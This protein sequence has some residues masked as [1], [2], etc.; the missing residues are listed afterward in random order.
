MVF[1]RDATKSKHI[2]SC[3]TKISHRNHFVILMLQKVTL[4]KYMLQNDV[5][6]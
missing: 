4:S 6:Q 3:I 1:V 5:L 2:A